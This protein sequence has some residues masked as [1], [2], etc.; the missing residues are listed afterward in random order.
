MKNTTCHKVL[1]VEGGTPVRSKPFPAWPS[2][3]DDMVD[4]A[5]QVLRS[6]R[7]NA[8]TGGEV[9]SFE[10]EF[11]EAV[12][13]PFA[14]AVANGTVALELALQALG[15]GAGDDV[16][17]PSRTFVATASSVA[18]RGATPVF[19]DVD[20]ASQNLTAE[21]IGAVLTPRTK[22]VIAVHLAGWPC[23]MDSILDLAHARGIKVVEDCAQAHGATY[24]GRPVGSL[25]DAGAFSFCQDKII[26]TAGEGGMVTCHDRDAWERAWSY[27]D[28]GKNR[29]V[30]DAKPDGPGFRL[31]H[32]NIGTNWRL[33][34]MQAAVGRV[35]L[36]RLEE[37][38]SKRRRYA[39]L[40]ADELDGVSALAIPMPPATCRHSYYK[41]YAFIRP[42]LVKG[43]WP[44]DRILRAIQAEGI[45]C[46]SGSCPEVYLEQAFATRGWRPPARLPVAKR[47]GETSLMFLVH[48]TLTETD[49][50]DTCRAVASV[51]HAATKDS[52]TATRKAA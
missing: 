37:W 38:V 25:G 16:V 51:F 11:A 52:G 23:D 39:R 3:D 8:W 5:V 49:I 24:K 47:L 21:G 28:H 10:K 13:V 26:T 29:Q 15:I 32:D 30:L 31:V 33:T 44:R 40:L 35:M 20:P 1:A 12:E 46:F 41:F 4:A 22:A 42:E 27:K 19:A 50:R 7:V 2:F 45:P 34:E 14:V 17:V 18:A 36:R 9:A 48:P 43:D 6:G